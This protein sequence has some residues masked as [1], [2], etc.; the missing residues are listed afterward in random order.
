MAREVQAKS[1]EG[2]ILSNLATVFDS[3]GESEKAVG[4]HQQAISVQQLLKTKPEEG[5]SWN[6]LAMAFFN[7]GQTEKA[8]EAYEKA[9]SI[10]R[11]GDDK[12]AA[13]GILQNYGQRRS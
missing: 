8:I 1:I 13:A 10:V 12:T 3:S 7:L 5:R 11:E 6:N 2:S 4:F 9:L